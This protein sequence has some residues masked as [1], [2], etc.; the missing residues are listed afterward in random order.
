MPAA[1]LQSTPAP[2]GLNISNTG[3]HTKS[4]IAQKFG[5]KAATHKQ[6]GT[7]LTMVWTGR[8]VSGRP[9]QTA[10]VSR[11]LNQVPAQSW[12]ETGSAPSRTTEVN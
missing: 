6:P 1:V 4:A 10:R 8:Q 9:I 5:L 3:E 7:I 11:P 12:L 2:C